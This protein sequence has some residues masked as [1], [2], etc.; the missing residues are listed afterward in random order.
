MIQQIQEL[1]ERIE[2]IEK[3]LNHVPSFEYLEELKG[4]VDTLKANM[5]LPIVFEENINNIHKRIDGLETVMF[6]FSVRTRIMESKSPCKC[7][8][9][10]GIGKKCI[11]GEIRG[12]P[13]KAEICHACEGKGIVWG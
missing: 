3:D 9:C 4:W 2:K 5:I 7:P 10:D 8:L 11:I 1:F 6:E 12:L 13:I